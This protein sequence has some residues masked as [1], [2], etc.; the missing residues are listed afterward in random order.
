MVVPDEAPDE[1]RCPT[2]ADQ[3]RKASVP[4]VPIEPKAVGFLN[5]GQSVVPCPQAGREAESVS[6][7]KSRKKR[8]FNPF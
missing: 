4:G 5:H 1:T 3:P 2:R 8:I 6:T 7:S